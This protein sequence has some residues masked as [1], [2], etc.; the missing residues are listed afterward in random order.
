M[1][2][3]STNFLILI[4]PYLFLITNEAIT[5]VHIFSGGLIFLGLII[6]NLKR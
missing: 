2:K 6:A 3:G 5:P 1:R 4:L